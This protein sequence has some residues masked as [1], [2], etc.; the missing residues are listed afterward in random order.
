MRPHRHAIR[1]AA[2]LTWFLAGGQPA[3]ATAQ[4]PDPAAVRSQVRS[5]REARE[6]AIVRELADLLA[7]PNNAFDSVNIRR[8]ARHLVGMLE[9]RG[10]PARLLEVPGSPPAVYGELMTPG[11]D[12]T[13]VLYAH[14]DGQPVDSTRWQSRPWS[15]MLR[16]RALFDGGVEIPFPTEGQ[17]LDPEA[18]IY[19]RSASDD[20][21]PIVAMLTALDALRAAGVPPS[22]NLKFFFEGEEE[23]GSEHLG[24]MLR[25]HADLLKADLWLFL[26]GPVHQTRRPMVDFGVRGVIGVNLTVFGPTRPLHSGHY[27]NWAPNPNA[28]LTNLLASMRDMDGRITI[29][30]YYDDVRPISE[31][32]RK[33]IAEVPDA[34]PQLRRDFGLAATE[35]GN[36]PLLERLMLPAFNIG[37]LQGGLTGS[38]GANLIGTRSS[39]YVDLRL[40]PDQQPDRVRQLVEAH[41]DKQGFHIVRDVPDSATRSRYPRIVQVS[42]GDGY[43][44]LRT[45]M[46]LP[47]SQA[48]IRTAE[49]AL[50]Q[51]IVQLPTSGGSLGI[52]HFDQVLKVPLIFVPIVNHDNN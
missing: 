37:G 17:R 40:V 24:A 28:L 51:P 12:R 20:K 7:I 39:A 21:S 1:A 14:Y 19:A 32:E 48:V 50:G 25:T 4:G 2:V 23:A 41:I 49:Q 13:V 8:N 46:D 34:D 29:D 3:T 47:V 18:R 15:P 44:A 38:G 26:D 33:A 5:Y 31:A 30:G 10:I 45:P 11:A 16:S 42:W 22:V 52:Y 27:G 36:A 35:A 43:P 6:A 9:G